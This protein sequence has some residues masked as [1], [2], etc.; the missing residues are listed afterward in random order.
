MKVDFIKEK[1]PTNF[2]NIKT[3]IWEKFRKSK[4]FNA[5]N[6]GENLLKIGLKSMK[7]FVELH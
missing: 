4:Q 1:F 2:H 5:L 6:V 3:K 7:M